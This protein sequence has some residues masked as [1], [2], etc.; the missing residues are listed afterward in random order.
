LNLNDQDLVHRLKY[1]FSYDKYKE[2]L[3]SFFF[4]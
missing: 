4:S 1:K 3:K 2:N